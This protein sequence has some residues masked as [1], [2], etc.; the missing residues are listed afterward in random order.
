M[1]TDLL[2]DQA[3]KARIDTPDF[4]EA[5]AADADGTFTADVAGYLDAWK[6]EIKSYQDEGVSQGEFEALN[7][8]NHSVQTAERV[9]TFFAQSRKQP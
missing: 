3:L 8:L 1:N 2:S 6:G 5:V 4:V 9:L 7:Q